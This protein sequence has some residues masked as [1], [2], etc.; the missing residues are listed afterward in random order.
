MA[1]FCQQNDELDMHDLIQPIAI[2][3][4]FGAWIA[5]CRYSFLRGTR[6]RKAEIRKWIDSQLDAQ[7]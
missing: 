7:R 6:E 5:Y 3:V 4:W 2:F 1:K